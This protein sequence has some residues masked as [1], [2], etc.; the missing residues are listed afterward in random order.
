MSL[1]A[2][3]SFHIKIETHKHK[4][5]HILADERQSFGEPFTDEKKQ[6]VK[7]VRLLQITMLQGREEP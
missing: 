3:A 7:S 6:L 2:S 4:S 5:A 1:F